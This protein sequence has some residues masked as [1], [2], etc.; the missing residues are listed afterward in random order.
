MKILII[1]RYNVIMMFLCDLYRTKFSKMSIKPINQDFD[2]FIIIINS[3]SFATI[4]KQMNNKSII[5]KK[6][7][8][9]RVTLTGV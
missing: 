5:S 8:I 4:K 1:L 3:Y 6:P 2:A 7:A 9:K